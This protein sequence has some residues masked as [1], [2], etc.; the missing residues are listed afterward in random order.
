MAIRKRVARASGASDEEIAA[1]LDGAKSDIRELALSLIALLRREHPDLESSARFGWRSVNFRHPR[2][3]H[4][5]AVFPLKDEVR[6]Y[7]EHGRQ[8][9]DPEGLL[10]GDGKQ[11]RALRLRPGDAIPAGAIGLFLAE[12]IALKG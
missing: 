1:L 11:V 7:F 3:G 4:L 6:L 10:E 9:S 5:C 12:A 2:V 8:L